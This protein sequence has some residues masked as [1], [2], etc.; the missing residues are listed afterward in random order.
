ME[1]EIN[2]EVS[3]INDGFIEF[4]DD[5]G[6]VTIQ[7]TV[8][9]AKKIIKEFGEEILNQV[10]KKSVLTL[11]EFGR[12]RVL[13]FTLTHDIGDESFQIMVIDTE[14]TNLFHEFEIEA[15]DLGTWNKFLNFVSNYDIR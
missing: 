15:C 6:L 3:E 5:D 7:V 8:D 14:S 9:S 12:N 2:I 13:E 11:L 10:N 4:I 1:W